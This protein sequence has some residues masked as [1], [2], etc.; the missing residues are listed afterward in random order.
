MNRDGKPI[1]NPDPSAGLYILTRDGRTVQARFPADHLAFQLGETQQI[2]SGGLLQ[3]TPHCV[4]ACRGE[5]AAGVS[6]T[7]FAIFME[8]MWE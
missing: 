2:Q 6:R 5:D 1:P 3:A 8:P 4:T 7:T